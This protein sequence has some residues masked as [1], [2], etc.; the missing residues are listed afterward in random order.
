MFY[1]QNQLAIWQSKTNSCSD[2]MQKS[3]L[4]LLKLKWQNTVKTYT[5]DSNEDLSSKL[6]NK[7]WLV[8][9]I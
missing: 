5:R 9:Y 8:D 2:D 7:Q 3:C 6:P 4:W 1:Y